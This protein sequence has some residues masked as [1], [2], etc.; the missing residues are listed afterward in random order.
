MA[1]RFTVFY[2][3]SL[4]RQIIFGIMSVVLNR[5]EI[6]RLDRQLPPQSN[7]MFAEIGFVCVFFLLGLFLRRSVWIDF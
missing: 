2:S 1:L 3:R 6:E 5:A 4:I 7:T